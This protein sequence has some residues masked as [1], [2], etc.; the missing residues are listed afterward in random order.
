M[1]KFGLYLPNFG[2]AISA[3][4]I[5]DLTSEAESAGW[6]GFF[7]WDH[8][9]YSQTQLSPMVDPWIALTA[10]AVQTENIRLGTTVTPLARRRPWVLARTTATLDQLSNGRVILSVGLGEPA[11]VEFSMFG[12][13]SD[14]K[15]RAEKLDESL[16]I[17]NGLWKGKPFAH[18][19][20]HYQISKMTFRPP[21]V[22]Q[23][24]I[25]I[26]VGGFWPNQAPFRR[27][28]RWDG[29]IPLKK[30]G[31]LDPD[32]VRSMLEFIYEHRKIETQLDMAII[33]YQHHVRA[34]LSGKKKINAYNQAGATWWLESL[35]TSRNSMPKLLE[36]IRRGPPI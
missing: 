27:A 13:Q 31:G 34:G 23:P 11:K 10:A 22:Q 6:N 32:D 29:V 17:L 20:K 3:H 9:L 36:T 30:A 7:L 16:E 25:P 26:W 1:V 15:V 8:I 14:P 24:R 12:E 21:V 18:K 5:A 35:F 2:D 4:A 19:G 33:G 28:A